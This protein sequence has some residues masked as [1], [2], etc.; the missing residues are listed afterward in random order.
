M[1]RFLLQVAILLLIFAAAWLRGGRPEREV[2]CIYV[3]MLILDLGQAALVGA[4][5]DAQY[6]NFNFYR[7]LLDIAALAAVVSVAIRYDR[8]WVLWVG[9]AHLLAVVAH[10]LRAFMVPLPPLVYA[11]MERWP[12]WLAILVTGLGVLAHSRREAR[13]ASD[14]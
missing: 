8:W 3:S 2:A 9:S 14:I 6:H 11:I 13:K 5:A 12:V 10:V 7:F 4:W 1:F